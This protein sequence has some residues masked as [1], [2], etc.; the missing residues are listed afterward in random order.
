MHLCGFL[1]HIWNQLNFLQLF[2]IFN[3]ALIQV[4]NIIFCWLFFCHSR[5]MEHIYIVALVIFWLIDKYIF[6]CWMLIYFCYIK[7]FCNNRFLF[8][9]RINL[10]FLLYCVIF[11]IPCIIQVYCNVNLSWSNFI[12]DSLGS[13][14]ISL[15]F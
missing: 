4:Y 9:L 14:A 10:N 15:Q 6:I 12:I 1:N 13:K 5:V 2:S 11:C 8:P 7:K 3:I